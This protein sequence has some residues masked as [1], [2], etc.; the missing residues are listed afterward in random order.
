MKTIGSKVHLKEVAERLQRV[1]A[2]GGT[3]KLFLTINSEVLSKKIR[4]PVLEY[5]SKE[6]MEFIPKKNV[7]KLCDDIVHADEIGSYVI[8]GKILQVLSEEN[9][10]LAFRKAEEYIIK[11]DK[12]YVCDIIGERV[13]GNALLLQPSTTIS[14][15]KKLAAHKVNWMVRSVGV[16][17][18]YATKKGLE[19]EYCRQMFDILLSLSGSTDFHTKKGIGWA[20]KT[21]A[22]FHPDIIERN[23]KI[24][25]SPQTKQWFRSKVK[26]GLG[27]AEYMKQKLQKKNG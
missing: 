25:N 15:M 17:T 21:I 1:Y 22:K 12:W 7:I 26:M 2:S 20:A 14:L 19:K 11:G 6:L 9:S 24:L 13:F 16:A 23:N 27:R 5:F 18:H 8:A 3:E 4:F 10:S